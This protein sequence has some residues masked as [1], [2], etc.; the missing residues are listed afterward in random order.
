MNTR[1]RSILLA[2]TLFGGMLTAF[3][4]Q[5]ETAF[6]SKQACLDHVQAIETQSLAVQLDAEQ[7]NELIEALVAAT[8]LCQANA[9]SDAQ[10][11][12]SSAAEIIGVNS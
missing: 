8:D 3:S 7:F 6:A 9:L 4:A 11:H 12:L 2:A 1:K 5:A 10:Q